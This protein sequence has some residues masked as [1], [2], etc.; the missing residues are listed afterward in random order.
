MAHA[1]RWIFSF[2]WK[3][4]ETKAA[5]SPEFLDQRES[6]S[7]GPWD[8]E[9]CRYW[10]PTKSSLSI[11]G[12]ATA[13]HPVGISSSS[14]TL[15]V[16][17]MSFFFFF[18]ACHIKHRILPKATYWF[19]LGIW[20]HPLRVPPN[21]TLWNECP[22]ITPR[23]QANASPVC[24][25]ERYNWACQAEVPQCLLNPCLGYLWERKTI[26]KSGETAKH[27]ID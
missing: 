20:T 12:L 15:P 10:S 2:P 17:L 8:A 14:W 24:S 6:L 1:L 4:D 11:L 7:L 23:S 3:L 27:R 25:R 19:T 13:R 16:L 26:F 18:L 22:L 9:L 5:T 21:L